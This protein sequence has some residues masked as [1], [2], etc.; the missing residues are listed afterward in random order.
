MKR[1]QANSDED[2]DRDV[3]RIAAKQT[4]GCTLTNPWKVIKWKFTS[5]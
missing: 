2:V 1:T 5:P 3:M 4:F